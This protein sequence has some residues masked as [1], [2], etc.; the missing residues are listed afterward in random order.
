MLPDGSSARNYPILPPP[1]HKPSRPISF[2]VVRFSDEYK[3]NILKSECL[4]NPINQ[5]ITIDN[6]SNLYY[7]NLTEAI[8]V[9]IS[10]ACHDLIAVVH[11][12]VLLPDG[13]QSWFEITLEELEGVD[14]NWGVLGAV[15]WTDDSKGFGHYSD[16]KCYVNSFSG[17]RFHIV[18]RL[19][20]QILIF[21]RKRPIDLDRD[22]PSIHHIG[23][24]ITALLQERGM[25][26]YAID[27]PT[28]HKYADQDGKIIHSRKDSP[29]IVDRET[30]TYKAERACCDEYITHKWPHLQ[31]KDFIKPS[32]T[33]PDMDNAIRRKLDKPIILLARG[34]GGSRLISMLCQDLGLFLGNELN[35]AGDSMEMVLP[36]YQGIIEKYRCKAKWQKEQIVPRI[37]AA[38][39]NMLIRQEHST[40]LWGFKLPESILLLPEI[41][42]VFPEA[43]FL[44]M[45]RDPLTTCLRRTH[46]TARLDNSIGR[47][48]LPLAYDYIGKPR[49][50]ILEDS[51]ALHMAYTTI[52]Q[53]ELVASQLSDHSMDRGMQI[54][55]ED[56][57]ERPTDCL[58]RVSK[59]LGLTREKNTLEG[60]I[61]PVRIQRPRVIYSSDVERKVDNILHSIRV[62]YGYVPR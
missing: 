53:L 8:S 17:E 57:I 54:R 33:L 20:E 2:V 7:D 43:R 26:A 35:G 21:N 38:A 29:K 56:I 22:L 14:P 32:L 15:G 34:G 13:W 18:D 45:V 30:L 44:H 4:R 6:T 50:K 46:M 24:D 3:H 41:C 25:R 48:S 62:K 19:D 40:E 10:K 51:P 36:I 9:G 23:R 52:H 12:D 28:I 11:E 61:D 39:A 5:V 60:F 1:I 49:K 31:V 55:F 37:R 47:I 59:W 16:P 27:A 42:T 58:E